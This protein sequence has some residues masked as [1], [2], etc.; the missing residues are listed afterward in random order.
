MSNTGLYYEQAV[1]Q[2][3]EMNDGVAKIEKAVSK[4]A[5]KWHAYYESAKICHDR[6]KAFN[7]EHFP[8]IEAPK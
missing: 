7:D 1:A 8:R 5:S 2:I 6:L 3:H 4:E